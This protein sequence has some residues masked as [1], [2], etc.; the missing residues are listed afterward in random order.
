[1]TT[2]YIL[3]CDGGGIKGIILIN[4]LDKL[5]RELGKKIYDMFDYFSGA[6]IGA[7]IISGIIYSKYTLEYIKH[8]L[9]TDAFIRE[10]FNSPSDKFLYKLAK[11]KENKFTD[12]LIN[13]TML[14]RI[15]HKKPIYKKGKINILENIFHGIKLHDN[16]EKKILIPIFDCNR[17]KPVYITNY[18]DENYYLKDI[19]YA[20]ITI[21]GLYEVNTYNALSDDTAMLAGLDGG[22]FR[23]N[24]VD[25]AYA[26]AL[27]LW[28]AKTPMKIF[29][30]GTGYYYFDE[31]N[32]NCGSKW[33][34]IKWLTRGNIINKLIHG[35][36]VV[37]SYTA[38]M[39]ADSLGH[40]FYRTDI[41]IDNY[42][43]AQGLIFYPDTIEELQKYSNLY[44]DMDK[45]NILKFFDDRLV[46][47]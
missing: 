14:S 34:P 39:I 26:Y 17:N 16:Q 31:L 1:M 11:S 4:L 6:S 33:G 46:M 21:P 3:S 8:D 5:E 30:M 36:T 10:V 25:L 12:F 9:V 35:N 44:W 2:K 43:Y 28:G 37:T 18:D 20:A 45:E 42:K 23:S 13:M 40:K 41:P 15:M 32:S 19:C 22:I 24:P 29:S 27:K 47:S 38:N 7:V